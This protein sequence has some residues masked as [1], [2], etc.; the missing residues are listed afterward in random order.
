MNEIGLDVWIALLQGV[1]EQKALCLASTWL[2]AY[3][4]EFERIMRAI[5]DGTVVPTGT[6]PVLD[7]LRA[8][9]GPLD[10]EHDGSR[11]ALYYM[12]RALAEIG[13]DSDR[14][15]V[16]AAAGRL[17]PHGLSVNAATYRAEVGATE[18]FAAACE[19]VEVKAA[20]PVMANTVKDPAAMLVRCVVAGRELGKGLKQVDAHLTKLV[21]QGEAKA[22]EG[23]RFVRNDCLRTW[24]MFLGAIDKA[25]PAGGADAAA[26]EALIGPY[27]REVEKAA[28]PA[29]TV[30][31]PPV[32]TT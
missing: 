20:L 22:S 27:L 13:T 26:R 10:K 9:T 3:P 28:K 5:V 14:E 2:A 24:N 17:F 31:Q 11:R 6:D 15:T 23:L 21:G 7:A 1:D 19:S 4:D 32:V 30:A 29:K 8:A 25:Y 12:L 18:T 16:R